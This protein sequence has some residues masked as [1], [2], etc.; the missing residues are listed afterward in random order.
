MKEAEWP[1]G[2]EKNRDRAN[3]FLGGG[4]QG[5]RNEDMEI[6]SI[7]RMGKT[8]ACVQTQRKVLVERDRLKVSE[9]RPM[10]RSLCRGGGHG[11]RWQGQPWSGHFILGGSE[12]LELDIVVACGGSSGDGKILCPMVL[13]AAVKK[14]DPASVQKGPKEKV[15]GGRP[16]GAEQGQAE[17]ME[18]FED[19]GLSWGRR[20]SSSCCPQK[21]RAQTSPRSPPT[22]F[23]GSHCP[24]QSA[25]PPP[26]F[27]LLS[28]SARRPS[29]V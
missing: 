29:R 5:P 25:H 23:T 2:S 12:D 7:F 19:V 28:A 21:D 22:L 26:L 15:E 8:G 20:S 10:E 6:S 3:Q 9:E 1:P 13:T 14:Q 17:P 11:H 4:R 27:P 16:Q 24:A 18:G